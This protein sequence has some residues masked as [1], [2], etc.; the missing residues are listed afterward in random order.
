MYLWE[1]VARIFRHVPVEDEWEK[2]PQSSMQ[3]LNYRIELKDSVQTGK[4]TI[5]LNGNQ[6]LHKTK[7]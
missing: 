5:T 6:I 2:I 4:F 1:F 7:M 3:L